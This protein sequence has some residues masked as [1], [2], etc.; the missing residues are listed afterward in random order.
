M[1]WTRPRPSKEA[2]LKMKNGVFEMVITDMR[3]ESETAGYDSDSGG[4][5]AAVRSGHSDPHGV[6]VAG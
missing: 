3:M 2:E 4:A 6:P 5:P 1:K